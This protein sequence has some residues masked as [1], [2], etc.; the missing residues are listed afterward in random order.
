MKRRAAGFTLVELMVATGIVALLLAG[1]AAFLHG[2]MRFSSST[3]AT[4]DR[5]RELNDGSGYVVDNLRRSSDVAVGSCVD[6]EAG[7][8]VTRE[9]VA[10]VVPVEQA[11]SLEVDAVLRLAYLRIPRSAFVAGR[12]SVVPPDSWADAHTDVLVEYRGVTPCSGDCTLPAADLTTVP[13]GG[14]YLVLD[15]LNADA[16]GLPAIFRDAGGVITLTLQ[17]AYRGGLT[18]DPDPLAIAVTPRN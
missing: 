18:P 17:E 4:S 15:G 14:P 10:L 7:G 2:T 11:A 1:M 16:G 5:L 8:T 13:S 12:P 3:I 6:P 9:C